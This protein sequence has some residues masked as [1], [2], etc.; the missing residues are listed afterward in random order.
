MAAN[1]NR[2]AVAGLER[3]PRGRHTLSR[4]VVAQ[5]QRSRLLFAFAEAVAAHGYAQTTV[6]H[7]IEGAGVSRKAFYAHF[8]DLEDAFLAAFE[9]IDVVVQR[10]A[11]A[12]AAHADPRGQV[13]AGLRAYLETLA[14]EP[15]FARLLVLEASGAGPR[16]LARRVDTFQR[17]AA[18]LAA[19][20]AIAGGP[21]DQRLLIALLGAVNELVLQ[22]MVAGRADALPDLAP[23]VEP[24]L[25]AV[26]FRS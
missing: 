17:F 26:L 14:D 11:I 10:V 5:S 1:G 12:A 4:E 13:R 3:L 7:V 18:M 2:I 19:P 16:V 9:A 15:E 20:V 23:V 25:D 22:E 6:A 8:T 21:V 24:V